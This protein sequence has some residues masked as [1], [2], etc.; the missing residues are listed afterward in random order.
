MAKSMVEIPRNKGVAKVSGNAISSKL[1]SDGKF[2]RE[3][4]KNRNNNIAVCQGGGILDFNTTLELSPVLVAL[5]I[6]VPSGLV[7]IFFW[8]TF[9]FKRDISVPSTVS[10]PGDCSTTALL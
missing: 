8:S 3:R 9:P 4:A 5:F 10:S 6:P 1:C 7:E 2:R